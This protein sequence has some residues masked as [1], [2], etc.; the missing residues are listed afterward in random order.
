MIF[1]F[2]SPAD[3]DATESVKVIRCVKQLYALLKDE[4]VERIQRNVLGFF[5]LAS[6]FSL[7]TL[8]TRS[9]GRLG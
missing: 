2:S 6:S 8:L 7:D 9:C 3:V 4:R 5:I 1:L